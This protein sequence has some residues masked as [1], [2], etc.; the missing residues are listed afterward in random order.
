MHGPEPA[1]S[2]RAIAPGPRMIYD[3]LMA[4]PK[5]DSSDGNNPRGGEAAGDARRARLE[6]ELRANILKRKA[7]NRARK[8]PQSPPKEGGQT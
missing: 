7:Q 2:R 8:A 5:D 4:G 1:G 3:A 6:Q